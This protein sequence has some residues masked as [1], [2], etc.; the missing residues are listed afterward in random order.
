MFSVLYTRPYSPVQ[1][2]NLDVI[3]FS[4]A[5]SDN[6]QSSMIM[7]AVYGDLTYMSD[8]IGSTFMRACETTSATNKR[9]ENAFIDL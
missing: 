5:E 4:S 7:T 6:G 3:G 8:E 2:G 1:G 9:D